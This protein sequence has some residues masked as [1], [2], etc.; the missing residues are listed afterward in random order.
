MRLQQ[1]PT[2]PAAVPGYL[3]ADE[4]AV[5]SSGFP[6]LDAGL[7]SGGWPAAGLVELAAQQH[8]ALALQLMLPLLARLSK[9]AGE[10]RWIA[11]VAPP[12]IPCRPGLVNAGVDVDRLLLVHPG[13]ANGIDVIE[14]L[15]ANGQCAAVLAWPLIDE[16][17]IQARLRQAAETGNSLAI[18]FHGHRFAEKSLPDGYRIVLNPGENRLEVR[19]YHPAAGRRASRELCLPYDQLYPA[20]GQA[21]AE[22]M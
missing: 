20:P 1:V 4:S 7:P 6:T 17:L 8:T 11:L 3:P 13:A 15:L 16:P 10:A 2:T 5:V 9:P 12:F 14:Q 22:M 18:L 19:C 21:V